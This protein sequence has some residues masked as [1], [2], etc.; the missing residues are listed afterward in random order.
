MPGMDKSRLRCEPPPENRK[1]DVSAWHAALDNAHSQLEHQYN[2]YVP[3][4]LA[5]GLT[6]LE[7]L[8]GA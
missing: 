8:L 2:R 6:L 5:A 4:Y 7:L 3:S 1:N